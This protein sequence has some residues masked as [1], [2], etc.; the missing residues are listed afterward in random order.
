MT[1][2]HHTWTSSAVAFI[3]LCA[4]IGVTPEL[5]WPILWISSKVLRISLDED[6]TQV[7]L[8]L[9]EQRRLDSL[10]FCALFCCEMLCFVPMARHRWFCASSMASCCALS[11]SPKSIRDSAS[12]SAAWHKQ[13]MTWNDLKYL[14]TSKGALKVEPWWNHVKSLRKIL[15][16]KS[17]G[18]ACLRKSASSAD[19]L[20]GCGMKGETE[21]HN[22]TLVTL[23]SPAEERS[24]TSQGFSFWTLVVCSAASAAF[25]SIRSVKSFAMGNKWVTGCWGM[26]PK[27]SKGL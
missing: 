12:R 7:L 10:L 9:F 13:Y 27:H 16:A 22:H 26:L 5:K 23:L 20:Q 11:F 19:S 17:G 1:I 6:Q 25:L 18:R 15:W 2:K 4:W 8:D 3:R 24:N 21:T 14:E